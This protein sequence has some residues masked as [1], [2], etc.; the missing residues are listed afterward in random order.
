[1]IKVR[2]VFIWQWGWGELI[3]KGEELL[4]V[5][6]IFCISFGKWAHGCVHLSKHI[7][8]YTW[9]CVPLKLFSTILI[10]LKNL[11]PQYGFCM[12]TTH[13]LGVGLG[14]CWWAGVADGKKELEM[15]LGEKG[16]DRTWGTN[17][18]FLT[19]AELNGCHFTSVF[20]IVYKFF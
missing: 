17:G 11:L 12:S 16:Q 1:M 20:Q 2:S 7:K 5:L 19:P 10:K 8:L 3:T 6:E 15:D 9:K 14:H 4:G 13:S 18:F